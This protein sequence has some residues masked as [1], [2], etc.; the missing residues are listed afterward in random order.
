MSAIAS[1]SD[2]AA[3]ALQPAPQSWHRVFEQP[4]QAFAA[5]SL[6][7]IAGQIPP[8]L[9]G[10]FYQNGTGRL[11]RGGEQV[12]HWFDGDGAILRVAIGD[13]HAE[14][15]YRYVQT[16]G[17]VAESQA[18]CFSYGNYGRRYPG[19]LWKHIR[20]LFDGTSV[21][22]SANTSV[23]ALS[24]KLLA[25]WEAGN[26]HSLDLETLE[27]KGLE[28]LGWLTPTQQ[29]SAHPLQDPLSQEI[30][31]IGVTPQCELK[32]YRC[33]QHAQ[34][35]KQRSIVL[36]TV[37][38]VHSFVMAGPYLVFL[39]SPVAVDT[40]A[41]LLNRKSFAEAARWEGDR[42]TRII[43][44][45]RESLE[46]VS[47]SY[48]DA[49]YQWHYGNGCLESDGS[50]RLDFARFDDFTAINQVL[51]EVPSGRMS[52]RRCLLRKWDSPGSIHIC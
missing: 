34:L 18:N 7:L 41:L 12:G 5:T 50:V 28:S 26:P 11:Q 8:R 51:A 19:S 47:D 27:T 45:D 40:L 37:P 13:G 39:V 9:S 44:V 33:N 2:T 25:L 42:G 1:S 24:D 48:T 35:I 17:Y 32:L 21:K 29:F 43:V 31:S 16:Q 6:R 20:G 52:F 14:G 4:A 10:T 23:L 22:N 49:W 46:T 36:K 30:Y 38:I 15:T 3:S